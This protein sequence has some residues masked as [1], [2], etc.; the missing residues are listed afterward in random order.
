[1]KGCFWISVS[2]T[3]LLCLVIV[4]NG[5]LRYEISFWMSLQIFWCP[6]GIPP[7]LFCSLVP[8]WYCLQKKCMKSV[9]SSIWVGDLL[10]YFF[11][12]QQLRL[13]T[14]LERPP[15][16]LFWLVLESDSMS[17]V[18]YW[19]WTELLIMS[20]MSCCNQDFPVGP[21]TQPYVSDAR[22]HTPAHHVS[23]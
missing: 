3:H 7:G 18:G 14:V 2:N 22:S 11:S 8:Y 1:M 13:I 21:L 5:V 4:E 16:G 20:R 6:S 23:E 9:S 19:V 15:L 10:N 17:L 12:W